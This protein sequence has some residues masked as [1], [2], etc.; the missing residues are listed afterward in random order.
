MNLPLKEAK[1]T[2]CKAQLIPQ[3]LEF[4][5]DRKGILLITQDGLAIG[6]DLLGG[7]DR[8]VNAPNVDDTCAEIILKDGAF[9]LKDR[10]S[11][12]GTLSLIHI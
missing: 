2:I 7:G 8:E 4:E 5:Q 6:P 3:D 12:L 1:S 9:W 10:A 11:T